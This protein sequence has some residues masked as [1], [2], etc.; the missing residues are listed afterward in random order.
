MKLSRKTHQ[1]FNEQGTLLVVSSFPLRGEEI[2]SRNAV[3]RYSQLLLKTFPRNKQIVVICEK[4]SGQDNRPYLLRKNILILP[5]YQVNSWSLFKDLYKVLGEFSAATD[6]LIQFEFSLFGKELITFCLPLLFMLMRFKGKRIFTMFHQIVLDLSTL[7]DQVNLKN[8]PFKTGLINLAMKVFYV[9][10]GWASQKV[11]VHD[12]L[13]AEKLFGLVSKRKI[14]VIPHGIDGFRFY[15]KQAKNRLRAKYGL[16]PNDKVI[17]AYGYHSWYKGTD[18]LVNAMAESK[19]PTNYKLL[20]AGDVA[21]T[22]K[23]QPHLSEYYWALSQ[24]IKAHPGRIIHTGFLPEKQVPEVFAIADLVV[25][26]YRARMS[27]SGALALTFQ[28]HKPFI[29]S[30]AFVENLWASDYQRLSQKAGF[31]LASGIFNLENEAFESTL[32][33]VMANSAWLKQSGWLGKQIAQARAW[34]KMAERYLAVIAGEQS[35]T[36]AKP[37]FT[38]AEPLVYEPTL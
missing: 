27:S 10:F 31:S 37:K 3:A 29:C 33:K 16:K 35:G 22:Q 23:N 30:T 12:Q 8:Q 15:S 28:Y 32:Q 1:R 18:F 21:P 5:T 6:V 34:N 17:L 24:Q 14:E 20:L 9:L 4:V 36:G 11:L 13:L 38:L 2:A 26:A 7:A 19:L 25:F